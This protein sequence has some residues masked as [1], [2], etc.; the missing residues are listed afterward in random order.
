MQVVEDRFEAR[1]GIG[2]GSPETDRSFA[3][4]QCVA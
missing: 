1:R 4:A 2:M 3:A